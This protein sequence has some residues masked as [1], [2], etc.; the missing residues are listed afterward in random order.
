MTMNTENTMQTG[1]QDIV[2]GLS[3]SLKLGQDLLALVREEGVALLAMDTQELF[4][5]SRQ[6]TTLLAKIHYLD[7]ALHRLL[8][9]DQAQVRERAQVIAQYKKRINEVRAEVLLKNMS[10][11]R[12]TEDTLGYLNDAIALMTRPDP[13]ETVYRVPGRSQ[14]RSKNLPSYISRAV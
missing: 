8:E 12:L 7:D 1:K 10:N 11:K 9:G 3:V 5:L 4:R 13:N 6:K 14:A 2:E